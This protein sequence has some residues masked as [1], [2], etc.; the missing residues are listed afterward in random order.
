MYRLAIRVSTVNMYPR[1]SWEGIYLF[2]WYYVHLGDILRKS[3]LMCRASLD[4]TASTIGLHSGQPIAGI[5]DIVLHFILY[6]STHYRPAVA[7]L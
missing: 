2:T 7:S 6:A 1:I 5:E 4:Q 3:R